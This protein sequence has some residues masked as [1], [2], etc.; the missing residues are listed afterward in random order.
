MSVALPCKA[1]RLNQRCQSRIVPAI[2]GAVFYHAK[3]M[4]SD[5]KIVYSRRNGDYG[6]IC[7]QPTVGLCQ[8]QVEERDSDD[9]IHQK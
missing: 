3:I 8:T 4:Q 9:S 2:G 5:G 1:K 6:I 7:A